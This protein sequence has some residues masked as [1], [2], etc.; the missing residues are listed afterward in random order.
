MFFEYLLVYALK[1]KVFLLNTGD[2]KGLTKVCIGSLG[3]ILA[4]IRMMVDWVFPDLVSFNQALLAKQGWRLLEFP[5]SLIA[6]IFKARYFLDFD[7][8][9]S[10]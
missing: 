4:H 9:A 6:R 1:L 7:F 2:Q 10:Y 8:F 5:N 3:N